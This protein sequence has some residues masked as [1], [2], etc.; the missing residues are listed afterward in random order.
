MYY[1]HGLSVLSARVHAGHRLADTVSIVASKRTGSTW[2]QELMSGGAGVCPIFEPLEGDPVAKRLSRGSED[3]ILPGE[4]VPDL[5]AFLALA[6]R[7]AHVTRWSMRLASQR[8][9]LGAERFVVKHVQL[10]R[11][12]GW[13]ADTFPDTPMVLVVRH[14]CAVVQSM[15][16][17]RWSGSNAAEILAKRPE[18]ATRRAVEILDG[19]ESPAEVFAALWA[20]EML[21][22]LGETD[23]HRTSLV[24]YESVVDDPAGTLGPV[25]EHLRLPRPADLLARS[26]RPSATT[27]RSSVVRASGDRLSGWVDRLDPADRVAVLAVVR[28]ADISGYGADPRPDLE[29]LAALHAQPTVVPGT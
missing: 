27:H 15:L 13:L 6:M 9:L 10:C 24:A 28:D 19:R 23:P 1:S 21:A 20:S 22:M 18:P 3:V 7:G 11:A 14:P 29:A 17:V 5:E 16:T 12:S 2:V 8:Q 25:M 4:D 26:G